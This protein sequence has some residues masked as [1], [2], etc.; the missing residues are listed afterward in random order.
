MTDLDS[1]KG[2]AN[3]CGRRLRRSAVRSRSGRRCPSRSAPPSAARQRPKPSECL[4]SGSVD[5]RR[6]LKICN[7]VVTTTDKGVGEG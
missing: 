5:A 7:S 4:Q 3:C 6:N 2:A 1:V